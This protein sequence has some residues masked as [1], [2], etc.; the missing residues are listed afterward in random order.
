MD[1]V[2]ADIRLEN[3]DV[4]MA[5]VRKLTDGE[6]FSSGSVQHLLRGKKNLLRY[7]PVS[8]M[9]PRCSRRGIGKRRFARGMFER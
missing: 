1:G 8:A 2:H 7:G 5:P 6:K 3:G 9:A 4:S